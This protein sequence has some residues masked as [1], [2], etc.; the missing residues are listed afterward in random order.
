MAQAVAAGEIQSEQES[1]EDVLGPYDRHRA[2]DIAEPS[3]FNTPET[4][5]CIDDEERGVASG[6]STPEVAPPGSDATN[7]VDA[8]EATPGA[9]QALGA[10]AAAAAA[11]SEQAL[12]SPGAEPAKI[13]NRCGD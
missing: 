4:L 3:G 5:V 11:S 13:N 9:E 8:A 2:D 7:S 1:D 6:F 10:A 12:A